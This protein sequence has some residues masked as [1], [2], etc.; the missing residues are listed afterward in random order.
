MKNQKSVCVFEDTNYMEKTKFELQAAKTALQSC[1][2]IWQT[3]DV[4]PVI[5]IFS[6]IMSP[7]KVY[8]DAITILAEPPQTG[9]RFQISKQVYIS[10]LDIPPIPESLYRACR[11]ARQQIYSNMPELW[12]IES[13]KIVLNQAE[14]ETL[15]NSQ[16]IFISDPDKI[17]LAK[18]IQQYVELSNSINIRIKGAWFIPNFWTNEYFRQIGFTMSQERSDLPFKMSI[19]PDRLKEWL[20]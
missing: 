20:K 18:D 2:D 1:L 17:S 8:V 5:D 19:L 4:G 9:G 7:Q 6:L 14:A 13:D 16:S 11:S 15:I 3:L 12:S 10:T